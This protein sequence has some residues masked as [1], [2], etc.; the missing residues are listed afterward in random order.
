MIAKST[1]SASCETKCFEAICC[2]IKFCQASSCYVKSCETRNYNIYCY[3]TCSQRDH[4]FAIATFVIPTAAISTAV[5]LKAN[6]QDFA[7]Q[8]VQGSIATIRIIEISKRC[9]TSIY[10]TKKCQD[11]V[12]QDLQ[13]RDH[14]LLK[15]LK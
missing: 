7:R 2:D 3:E 6:I 1:K 4:T 13:L 8:T 9:D 14:T 10:R 12:L 11:E 15:Q 5:R